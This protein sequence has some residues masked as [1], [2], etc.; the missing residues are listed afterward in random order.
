M[1]A[2]PRAYNKEND[3]IMK[4]RDYRLL[5]VFSIVLTFFCITSAVAERDYENMDRQLLEDALTVEGANHPTLDVPYYYQGGTA[6]CAYASTSMLLSYLGEDVKPK[7]VARAFSKGPREGT[8][9]SELFS[10]EY[11]DYIHSFGYEAEIQVWKR[12]YLLGG[13]PVLLDNYIIGS[14]ENRNPVFLGIDDKHHAIVI[15]GVDDVGICVHDPSGAVTGEIKGDSSHRIGVHLTWEEFHSLFSLFS[16]FLKPELTTVRIDAI[17]SPPRFPATIELIPAWYDESVPLEEPVFWTSPSSFGFMSPDDFPYMVTWD[18]QKKYGYYTVPYV[19]DVGHPDKDVDV[20]TV[21]TP[22]DKFDISVLVTNASENVADLSLYGEIEEIGNGG[23]VLRVLRGY[24]AKSLLIVPRSY[25]RVNVFDPDQSDTL[26]EPGLTIGELGFIDSDP[27]TIQYLRITTH[28]AYQGQE[29]DRLS[30]I[31]GANDRDTVSANITLIIDG[32]AA[33][34]SILTGS[35]IT[36][37]VETISA[38]NI[39]SGKMMLVYDPVVLTPTMVSKTELTLEAL[40][41]YNITPPQ[42]QISLASAKPLQANGSLVDITFQV[43]RHVPV[44]TTTQIS[45]LSARLDEGNIPVSTKAKTLAVVGPDSEPMILIPSIITQQGASIVVPIE[46]IN[47]QQ[48]LSGSIG[49]RYDPSLLTFNAVSKADFTKNAMLESHLEGNEI[50]IAFASSTDIS[51]SG[52]LLSLSFTVASNARSGA[53]S[54]LAFS[55]FKLDQG[56]II[57]VAINGAVIVKGAD[58]P[59][60]S[61]PDSD[62][63][64]GSNITVPLNLDNAHDVFSGKVT[65]VYDSSILTATGVSAGTMAPAIM[66]HQAFSIGKIAIAFASADPINGSGTL[67]N[68]DFKVLDTA[69]NG[70]KVVLGLSDCQFNE[71]E[72]LPITVHGSFVV[73]PETVS[74][75]APKDLDLNNDSQIDFSDLIQVVKSFGQEVKGQPDANPDV[76]GDGVVNILDLILMAK[77]LGGT[78]Q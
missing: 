58:A 67:I 10:Q 7:D 16:G 33:M 53:R 64:P 5:Q 47:A 35:T 26:F 6:W 17:P 54:E 40:L 9:P 51:G 22:F 18:G 2:I 76:N 70:Y 12:S 48:I 50:R 27:E 25:T 31:V 46:I 61:L 75:L 21:L 1:K 72:L 8:P 23:S 3:L 34:A 78:I 56:T 57:P 38:S 41:E 4:N 32:S 24:S 69:P 74:T 62:G 73:T 68:I 52:K 29:C 71:N 20:G 66:A 65:L 36:A 63:V 39:F 14:I 11:W 30:V 13:S 55:F 42:I 49:I 44:G 37:S 60:V 43:S 77:H 45:F 59:T 28:V 19:I 15:V